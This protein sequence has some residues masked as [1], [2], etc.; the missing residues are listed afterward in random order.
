CSPISGSCTCRSCQPLMC[1]RSCRQGR[2]GVS[3]RQPGRQTSGQEGGLMTW[4]RG[5]PKRP[6]SLRR[7]SDRACRSLKRQRSAHYAS[8]S[9]ASATSSAPGFTGTTCP[10]ASPCGTQWVTKVCTLAGAGTRVLPES[11]ADRAALQKMFSLPIDSSQPRLLVV[12]PRSLDIRGLES[13]H[14]TGRLERRHP[15][16]SPGL[17]GAT[18][19]QCLAGRRPGSAALLSSTGGSFCK[20][21]WPATWVIPG[22]GSA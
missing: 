17:G 7:S 13:A 18:E 22:D 20:S 14:R 19:R 11:K 3:F 2:T 12:W 15:G 5:L 8:D 6:R 1:P 10:Y 21:M 16:N 9:P 4:G